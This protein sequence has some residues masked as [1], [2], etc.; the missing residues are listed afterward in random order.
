MAE[1]RGVGIG[2]LSRRS[3]VNIE[4]IRY[5]E[6]IGILPPPPRTEGGHRLYGDDHLKRLMFIRRSR[7]LGFTLDEIRNLLGLVEGG[8]TCGEVKNA[9]LAHLNDIRR[10][11]A[12]LRRMERTLSE[13]AARCEGGDAPECPIMEALF[14]E[15]RQG[16]N[17]RRI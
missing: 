5:Y 14:Q 11:I 8:Y 17:N 1:N 10:K 7:E 2:E 13:T 4:T 9:A 3:G 15:G 12:D 6:K 16:R